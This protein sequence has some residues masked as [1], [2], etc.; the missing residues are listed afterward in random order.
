MPATDPPSSNTPCT[1]LAVDFDF[2]AKVERSID[3][4]EA[5]AAI[6][7]GRFVW[8]DVDATDP[9]EAR[10]LLHTFPQIQEEII[11]AALR[12]EP[13]T[14]HAR[15]DDYVHL[16]VSGCRQRGGKFDLERVDA[17]IA[18]NFLITVHRG[19]V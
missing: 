1:V 2:A 12:N 19:P 18:Q 11:D 4:Q 5:P 15:Y 7:A 6:S 3:V 14:Q 8:V 17:I 9:V 10:R 13:S 16:V